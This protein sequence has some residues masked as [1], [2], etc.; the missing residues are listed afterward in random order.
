MRTINLTEDQF[1]LL[2]SSLATVQDEGP[3]NEGWKSDELCSLLSL[4]EQTPQ[5]GSDS[6]E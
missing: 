1:D 2:V 6:H 3:A 5:D 4:I